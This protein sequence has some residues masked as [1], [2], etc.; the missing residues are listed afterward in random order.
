MIPAPYKITQDATS[1]GAL[2]SHLDMQSSVALKD[3]RCLYQHSFQDHAFVLSQ[4]PSQLFPKGAPLL[5]IAKHFGAL[6]PCNMECY[7]NR[8]LQPLEESHCDEIQHLLVPYT[9]VSR[10]S[11]I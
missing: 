9:F 11:S 1:I 8:H 10:C 7:R 2:F 5:S 6:P 3:R 4:Q